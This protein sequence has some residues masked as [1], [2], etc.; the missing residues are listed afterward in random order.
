MHE[1]PVWYLVFAHNTN[2]SHP[3]RSMSLAIPWPLAVPVMINKG[4][5]ITVH[6]G[7]YVQ[8]HGAHG[9]HLTYWFSM[10]PSASELSSFLHNYSKLTDL[11]EIYP[12][13]WR[14]SFFLSNHKSAGIFPK[15]LPLIHQPRDWEYRLDLESG[16]PADPS[17]TDTWN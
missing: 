9:D 2:V 7:R 12:W 1:T 11:V 13:S 14:T 10:A 5:I 16:H 3:S 17:D 6:S 15:H 4:I 8:L